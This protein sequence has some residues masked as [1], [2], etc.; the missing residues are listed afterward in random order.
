MF[1]I[2]GFV[3]KILI[4]FSVYT[5]GSKL[6]SAKRRPGTLGALDGVRFISMSWVILGHTFAFTLFGASKYYFFFFHHICINIL[7]IYDK[8]KF[9]H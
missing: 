2:S 4:A 6:L 3:G 7:A 9:L 1:F 8:C 5:N